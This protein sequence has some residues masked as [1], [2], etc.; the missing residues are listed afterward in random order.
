MRQQPDGTLRDAAGSA[1]ARSARTGRRESR[2]AARGWRG[3]ATRGA[4]WRR[5]PHTGRSLPSST[6]RMPGRGEIHFDPV[7][8][9]RDDRSVGERFSAPTRD[10]VRA[11]GST[12]TAESSAASGRPSEDVARRPR[13]GRG[14]RSPMLRSSRMTRPRANRR[15]ATSVPEAGRAFG[16]RRLSKDDPSRP[17]ASES[18]TAKARRRR[19][20]ET[21]RRRLL[22]PANVEGESIRGI[23]RQRRRGRLSGPSARDP[24]PRARPD[25]PP[26]R[27][28]DSRPT[29]ACPARSAEAGSAPIVVPEDERD[30]P[31]RRRE[32]RA[33][34]PSA[35]SLRPAAR[36][37]GTIER[38]SRPGGSRRARGVPNAARRSAGAC[39]SAVNGRSR[40]T[41][42]TRPK[43]VPAPSAVRPRAASSAARAPRSRRLVRSRAPR[44]IRP[45]LDDQRRPGSRAKG[46]RR[47]RSVTTNQRPSR[48]FD[49]R[50]GQEHRRKTAPRESAAS[51]SLSDSRPAKPSANQT[52]L[53]A[54][55]PARAFEAPCPGSSSTRPRRE[56]RPRRTGCLSTDV[57]TGASQ[58]KV[59]PDAEASL[60]GGSPRRSIRRAPR[61][62]SSRSRDPARCRR[63]SPRSTDRRGAAGFFA[64]TPGP[65]SST[66]HDD[67]GRP[68]A[69]AVMRD[70]S[71]RAGERLDGVADQVREDA[72]QQARVRLA[73]AT[74]GSSRADQTIAGRSGIG[75]GRLAGARPT[76]VGPIS[77]RGQPRVVGKLR[78]RLRAAPRSASGRCA[79]HSSRTRSNSGC[80]P[81][82]RPRA[83][84]R[85]RG[86]SASTGS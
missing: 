61:R 71:R 38:K 82:S 73:P 57:A 35:P 52:P 69:R 50:G 62:S 47:R 79:T 66:R 31:V 14:A 27:R 54:G 6:S 45:A 51:A 18:P 24:P 70:F 37:A 55:A 41:P 59:E 2:R 19:A 22:V 13:P 84:A 33:P 26:R 4:R 65:V 17:R 32:A 40:W 3:P 81:L 29:T 21:R 34:E 56:A 23:V 75:R 67:R 8:D 49:P 30:Q 10:G 68:A 72:R 76:S 36:F 78:R 15:P 39:V 48:A 60:L 25:V 58:R 63:S 7:A 77:G 1:P 28:L 64:A 11:R 44:R 43:R 74:P 20:D 12:D 80:A 46:P 53:P 9:P 42:R 5:T 83:D 86:G 85:R 16:E